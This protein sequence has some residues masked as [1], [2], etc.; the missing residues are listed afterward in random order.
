MFYISLKNFKKAFRHF[1]TANTK[2]N[3]D[4]YLVSYKFTILML[5]NLCLLKY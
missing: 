4:E 2:K 1:L 3:S 5:Q